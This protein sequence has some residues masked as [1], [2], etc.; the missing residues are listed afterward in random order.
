MSAKATQS[1]RDPAEGS[2]ETIEHELKRTTDHTAE[3]TGAADG[4]RELAPGDQAAPGTPGT[5]EDICPECRG[6][7]KL[8]AKPCP[9]CNGTGRIIKGIGGA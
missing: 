2:R 6:G 8:G 1:G 7:G 3:H 4:S 5:G 9:N